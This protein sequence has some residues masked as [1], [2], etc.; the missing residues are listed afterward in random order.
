L[1]REKF[2]LLLL[3]LSRGSG[4]CLELFFLPSILSLGP[5][6]TAMLVQGLLVCALPCVLGFSSCSQKTPG[7]SWGEEMVLMCSWC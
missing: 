3:G 5:E 6:R 2:V 7:E 1:S 4:C